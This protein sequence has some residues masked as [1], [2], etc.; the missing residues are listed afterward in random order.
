MLER[1]AE[2]TSL[3]SRLKIDLETQ[4]CKLVNMSYTYM[5]NQIQ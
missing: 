2:T 5:I 4:H 3:I 1:S